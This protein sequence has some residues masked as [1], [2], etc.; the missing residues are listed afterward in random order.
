MSSTT[1]SVE[2]PGMAQVVDVDGA[3]MAVKE[4]EEDRLY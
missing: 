4:E 1:N 3:K 2:K